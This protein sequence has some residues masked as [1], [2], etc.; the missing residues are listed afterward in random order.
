M[1][2]ADFSP[3]IMTVA[4]VADYLQLH[5][6]T[7]Y[8]LLKNGQIPTLKLGADWGF[9]KIEIDRWILR[10]YQET[11]RTRQLTDARQGRFR[12]KLGRS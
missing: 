4:S 6:T 12:A 10:Q 8:W 9:S 1:K 3:E 11:P 7:I 5:V 2:K